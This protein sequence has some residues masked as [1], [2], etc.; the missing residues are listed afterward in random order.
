V[1]LTVAATRLDEEQSVLGGRFSSAFSAGGSTTYFV[2]SNASMNLGRGWGAFASYRRGWT[3]MPG[4]G[5]LVDKGQLRTNAFAFDLAKVNA[6]S[7]GDKL[8]FRVMQPLRVAKGGFDLNVPISYDYATGAVAH[9]QR[10]FNLAPNSREIDYEVAYGVDAFGGNL[11]LNAFL[12]THPGHIREMQ[13]DVGGVIR[14]TL[15]F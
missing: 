8:A 5:A 12:R 14:Y 1:N 3:T 11:G 10:F 9:E 2:D 6:F 13:N 15:G 7:N 4:T